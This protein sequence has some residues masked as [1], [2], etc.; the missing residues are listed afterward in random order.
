M[1]FGL[2]TAVPERGGGR[3]NLSKDNYREQVDKIA[4]VNEHR[5]A[6]KMPLSE[7]VVHSRVSS[8]RTTVESNAI[9]AQGMSEHQ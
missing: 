1:G 5:N 3:N 9:R 6:P 2:A 7:S 8:L 4:T